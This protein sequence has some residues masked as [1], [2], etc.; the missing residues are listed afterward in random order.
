MGAGKS[1]V[2]RQLALSLSKDFFDSDHT[3]VERTGVD[4]TYIFEK[5][6]EEGFRQRE[7]QTIRELAQQKNIVLSTGGGSVVRAENREI[8]ANAGTVIYLHATV[9]Q[10]ANRTKKKDNRPLLHDDNPRAVLERLM[11]QRE[12]H[13]REVSD[14]VITTDNQ[15]VENVVKRILDKLEAYESNSHAHQF[16][17]VNLKTKVREYPIR[18]GKDALLNE[19][20]ELS[21]CPTV[22]ITDENV[23]ALYRKHLEA[24]LNPLAW[25]VIPASETS[26]SMQ[27]YQW[28]LDQLLELGVKR[29]CKLIGIGGGVVGDLTGFVA[30]TYMRGMQ[31]VHVP[32]TVLAMVDSSIGG[33][34]GINFAHGKNLVGSIYQP[35]QV[36]A[37]LSFLKT[38]PQHEYVSGLAEVIKYALIHKP[39]FLSYLE[40]NLDAIKERDPVVLQKIV[41]ECA[42]S[43]AR[44]VEQDEQ[45]F[46]V[47]MLLNLGHTFGH[48][49]EKLTEYKGFSHG[50]AVA[51]GMCMAADVSRE[52]GHIFLADVQRVKR[53]CKSV[54]LPITWSDFAVDDFMQAMAIDKKNTSSKQRFILLRGLGK[55]YV[56]E[57]LEPAIVEKVL[58]TYASSSSKG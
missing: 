39:D 37:D 34:T 47:R 42:E 13:Y 21:S 33:K 49:I 58:K 15:R 3:I 20:D 55:A 27:H 52:L 29:D 11:L 57:N 10:Q 30:A 32:T 51:I 41:T 1:A 54:G 16:D 17:I 25:L 31:L 18:I 35:H 22:V 8:I 23:D 48:A 45:D 9:E 6:G 50:E 36:I 56:E 14:V 12:K 2:G 4:I 19:L 5:E 46:G 38:L 40:N 44:I 26:K 24:K 53:V 43:K 28:L 7:T